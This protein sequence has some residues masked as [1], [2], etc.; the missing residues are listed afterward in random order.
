MAA[1][2]GL[3]G[4]FSYN[5][6]TTGAAQT[7]QVRVMSV[8][9]GAQQLAS[10]TMSRTRRA[11]YP[12]NVVA[13]LV[14]IQIILV[15]VAERSSFANFIHNYS[16]NYLSPQ[17][18]FPPIMTFSCPS[19]NFLQTGIPTQGFEWGNSVGAI[20]WTPTII[21]QPTDPSFAPSG[22]QRTGGTGYSHLDMAS[23]NAVIK[24]AP[25]VK[26]FIPE[27]IQLSGDTAPPDGGWNATVPAPTS[28]SI[29]QKATGIIQDI[30]NPLGHG[31]TK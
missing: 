13:T 28:Q 19:I 29:D 16:V 24:V 18:Q 10:E 7:Y 25:E 5:L 20:M 3:N 17:A 23:Y 22:I 6:P 2:Q 14:G 12:R 27:G 1:R 4:T 15:G 31:L 11:F 9:Y 8:G 21:M 30:F 26:Y